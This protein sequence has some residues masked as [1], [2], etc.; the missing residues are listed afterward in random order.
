MT[1]P[2]DLTPKPNDPR[3]GDYILYPRLS[4]DARWRPD[5]RATRVV[6]LFVGP[7]SVQ[8]IPADKLTPEEQHFAKPGGNLWLVIRINGKTCW[9]RADMVSLE[10]DV[11][12]A[13]KPQPAPDRAYAEQLIEVHRREADAYD[14]MAE[15]FAAQALMYRALA[16]TKRNH[17]SLITSILERTNAT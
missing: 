13:P 16:Q 15:N 11:K 7:K 9:L 6:K 2:V 10:P 14:Q 17:I 8:H 4:V 12:P 1:L 3:W 5:E